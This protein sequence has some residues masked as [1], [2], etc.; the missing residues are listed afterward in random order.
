MCSCHLF[1]MF[2]C[3]VFIGIKYKQTSQNTEKV[4]HTLQLYSTDAVAVGMKIHVLNRKLWKI[5]W[6]GI[7]TTYHIKLDAYITVILKKW[8][9]CVYVFFSFLF[10]LIIFWTSDKKHRVHKFNDQQH[11]FIYYLCNKPSSLSKILFSTLFALFPTKKRRLYIQ[12]CG[13]EID[14]IFFGKDVG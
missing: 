12:V 5:N 1:H 4:T 14:F 11:I 10:S 6:V 3:T 9:V 7:H 13:E 2:Y 8:E